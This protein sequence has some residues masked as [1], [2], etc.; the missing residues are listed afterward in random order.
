ML[1]QL[2]LCSIL[3]GAYY[4]QILLYNVMM[5]WSPTL[6]Q[7]TNRFQT[8]SFLYAFLRCEVSKMI[9]SV[10]KVWNKINKFFKAEKWTYSYREFV[11][12]PYTVSRK[13]GALN[14]FFWYCSLL[15]LCIQHWYY[16]INAFVLFLSCPALLERYAISSLRRTGLYSILCHSL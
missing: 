9:I 1:C 3:V 4:L 13:W 7:H 2:Y 15:G 14:C 6:V 16:Y 8:I 11:G 5:K 10:T 12:L